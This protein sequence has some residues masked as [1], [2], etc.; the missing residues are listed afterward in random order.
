MP[1][2][3]AQPAVHAPHAERRQ[4]DG[5]G[6]TVLVHARLVCAELDHAEIGQHLQRD[7]QGRSLI[8]EH[9]G[10]HRLLPGRAGLASAGSP[11]PGVGRGEVRVEQGVHP[12]R[13]AHGV[14]G[15]R[16]PVQVLGL[17]HDGERLVPGGQD[18]VGG[19]GGEQVEPVPGLGPGAPLLAGPLL[20]GLP[21]LARPVLARLVLARNEHQHAG[22]DRDPPRRVEFRRDQLQVR[23]RRQGVRAAQPP[24]LGERPARPDP[25]GHVAGRPQQRGDPGR[26]SQLLA[27]RQ[28]HRR[29]P[30]RTAGIRPA[31]RVPVRV[32]ART[33]RGPRRRVPS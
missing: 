23:G 32:T 7:G 22:G 17:Q 25:P 18:I 8:L 10:V 11:A 2:L 21:V 15:G 19:P 14:E 29:E 27:G 20:A 5:Q 6:A 9:T 33:R 1:P 3:R 28:A 26:G 12:H 4:G 30:G 13:A 24:G 31:L 16:H